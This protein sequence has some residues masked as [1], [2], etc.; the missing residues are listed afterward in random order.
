MKEKSLLYQIQAK[1][2]DHVILRALHSSKGHISGL[3]DM[4]HGLSEFA[5]NLPLGCGPHI[6]NNKPLNIIHS[7]H[8]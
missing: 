4:S 2:C 7:L 3:V 6:N 5:S 8:P 1:G